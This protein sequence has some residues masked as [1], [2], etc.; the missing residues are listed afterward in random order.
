MTRPDT[1]STRHDVD[2]T[3]G[4][5]HHKTKTTSTRP[6][7]R[8]SI[9]W[10]KQ[11]TRDWQASTSESGAKPDGR[12]PSCN[13]PLRTPNQIASDCK[14]IFE[15]KY[16]T[17]CIGDQHVINVSPVSPTHIIKDQG[18]SLLHRKDT[19]G[20]P[21][22]HLVDTGPCSSNKQHERRHSDLYSWVEPAIYSDLVGLSHLTVIK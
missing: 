22:L 18:T 20:T 13:H 14:T 8:P 7:G 5:R 9:L 1:T 16:Y 17:R 19:G 11:T 6:R 2:K 12:Q 21:L 15:L 4:H 10:M 3:G